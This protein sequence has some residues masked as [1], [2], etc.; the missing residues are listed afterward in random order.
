MQ[1]RRWQMGWGGLLL[2][3]VLGG[4]AWWVGQR[5]AAL[6]ELRNRQGQLAA[7][8]DRGQRDRAAVEQELAAAAGQLAAL[9][10]LRATDQ[11]TAVTAG[12]ERKAWL[13]RVRQLQRDFAA[14]PD[15]RIPEMQWLTDADWLR[16]AR[17]AEL[18]TEEGRRRARAAIRDA[19]SAHFIQRLR[20]ALR[21]WAMEASAG[22]V[23]PVEALNSYFE[24]P[25][26]ATILARY[27]LEKDPTAAPRSGREWVVRARAPID[28]DYDQRFEAHVSSNGNNGWRSLAAPR[29]WAPA[30]PSEKK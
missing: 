8:R 17:L 21:R 24:Q 2:A 18:A 30:V 29:A 9:K 13:A 5:E 7:E 20:P 22:G 10:Q 4:G 27:R 15:Q 25:V 11:T 6:T 12:G 1:L 14:H 3:G 19:A 28:A 23:I 26:E 16:V